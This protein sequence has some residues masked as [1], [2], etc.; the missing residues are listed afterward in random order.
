MIALCGPKM[1]C[2]SLPKKLLALCRSDLTQAEKENT[3]PRNRRLSSMPGSVMP[4]SD[5]MGQDHEA[6]YS[7]TPLLYYSIT[8]LL[9]DSPILGPNPIHL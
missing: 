8:L 9:H 3:S 1:G 7:N 4:R 2:D 5:A 6:Q